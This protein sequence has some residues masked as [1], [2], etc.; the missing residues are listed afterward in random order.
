MRLTTTTPGF[1]QATLRIFSNDTVSP[2]HEVQLAADVLLLP[3]CDFAVT[4]ETIEF[5]PVPDGELRERTFTFTNLGLETCLV[6]GLRLTS[7]SDSAFDLG[8]APEDAPGFREVDGGRSVTVRVRAQ[9]QEAESKGPRTAHGSV[10]FYVSS[11][12][13]PQVTVAL[14]ADLGPNCLTVAPNDL[15]FGVT[16]GHCS[17]VVRTFLSTIRAPRR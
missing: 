14:K 4:P 3:A 16:Q 15:D 6:S 13:R 5:G 17:S 11:P 2:V 9:P 8:A 12:T 7:A 1:K 10:E